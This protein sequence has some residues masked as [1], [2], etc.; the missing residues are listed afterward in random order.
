MS[1]L[2]DRR[3]KINRILPAG[4]DQADDGSPL[5]TGIVYAIDPVKGTVQVGIRGG[6]VVLPAVAGL[7]TS[8]GFARVQLDPNHG[9]PVC[10]LGPVTRAAGSVLC[11]VSGTGTGTVT[12][13]YNGT[14]YTIPTAA[15]TY[16]VGQSAWV[17]LDNWGVPVVAI[18]PSTTA[19]PGYVPPAPPPTGTVVT[20]TATIGPQ[21][22]GTWQGSQSRWNNWNSTRYGGG[23]NIYQGSYSSSGLLQGFAGYGDQVVNLGALSI[24]SITMQA[25]KND[26]N[27][28]SAALVVQGSPSGTQPGG[29]PSSSGDT[30]STPTIGPGGWGGLTFTTNMCTAFRTGAAKGLCAVGSDYGGFGGTA[31]PGSFVLQITYTKNA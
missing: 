17:S 30:A 11:G 19:A 2:L 28:L 16:T 10:V 20:A 22:S 24:V 1:D 14:V 26:T 18:G 25:R 3:G 27:G 23:S 12:I 4:P 21:W 7:Y 8:G 13:G 31:T 6:V 29:A 15:G 5:A 9:R